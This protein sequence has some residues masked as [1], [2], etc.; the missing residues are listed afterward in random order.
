MT[1]HIKVADTSMPH[2]LATATITV[3]DA[4]GAPLANTEVTLKQARH[5]FLFGNIL[6]DLIPWAIGESDDEARDAREAADWL[7][8]FNFG[9]LPFYWRTFEPVRGQTGTAAL[10]AAAKRFRELGLTLKGHPLL[11]HTMAPKWLIGASLDQTERLVRD[12]ITHL[13]SDF[14][15][16]IDIWDAINEAVIMPVFEAEANA[17]TPLCRTN[18]RLATVRLAFD[19]ARQANPHATLLINDFDLTS[20]YECLIEGVLATG[21][22]IDAIGLQTHMHQGYQ[23]DDGIAA[24][25]SRFARYGLPLHL[26]EASLVSGHLMPPEI[27]DLNDYQVDDW[28]TTEEDEA[29]QAE[30]IAG[31]YRTLMAEPAVAAATYW[32]LT[33]R[34]AW[35]GAPTGLT[36]RDGS[37]KPAYDALHSL[38]KGTWWIAPTHLVTDEAGRFEVTGFKGDYEISDTA[39]NSASFHIRSGSPT[40]VAMR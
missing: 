36:R 4:A 38:I 16:V 9:T 26:T 27:V 37:R 17:I 7:E 8:L 11:W 6:F 23:G 24:R 3:T 18:G 1:A 10:M 15:G 30:E 12:R 5:D 13:V 33:D 22:E 21:I 39:G 14:A 2:R 20:A 34:D 29:R 40:V 35:L 28:P 32:G 19:T 31:F 25:L